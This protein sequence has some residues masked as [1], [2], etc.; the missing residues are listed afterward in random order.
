MPYTSAE[1]ERLL[2]IK[3]HVLRYWTGEMPLIQPKKDTSG[4]MVYSG[5][6]IRLLLRLKHLLYRRRFS[7]E[8]ART[9]L[10]KELS[11]EWQD[12]RAELD[13]IRSGLI[14]LFFLA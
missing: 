12:L 1:A 13:A 2:G 10:E 14:E 5:R 4:R 9:Q 11:G 8:G 3:N 6:D 7:I